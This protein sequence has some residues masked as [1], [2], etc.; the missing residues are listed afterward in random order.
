MSEAAS[1]NTSGTREAILIAALEAFSEKGFDGASTRDIATRA[2]VNHGLIRYYFGSKPELWKKAVDRAFSQLRTLLDAAM[3]DAA[4]LGD[5]ERLRLMIRNFV[6]FAGHNPEFIRLMHEEGKRRGPRMRWI[7]DH[8][9]R[10][11]YESVH[12]LVERVGDKG[13]LRLASASPVHFHY[14]VVGA[15]T[16]IFHQAEECRR[17][18][19]VDPFDDEVIEEHARILADLFLGSDQEEKSA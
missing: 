11:V 18:S 10:P 4:L 14:I 8:Y 1:E 16:F 12:T 2:G 3:D 17:L 15:V 13:S 7:V 19:G 5:Q 6:R 9:V